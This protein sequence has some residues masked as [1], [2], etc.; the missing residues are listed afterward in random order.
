MARIRYGRIPTIEGEV[1]VIR[2]MAPVSLIVYYPKTESGREALA[3]RV[4]DVHAAAVGQKLKLLH[5]PT[6]QKLELLDAI[7]QTAKKKRREQAE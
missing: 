3:Q 1:T 5:C 2:K 4:S 7:I 6:H